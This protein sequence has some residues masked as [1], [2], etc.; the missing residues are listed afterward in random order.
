MM[1]LSF[2]MVIIAFVSSSSLLARTSC[3]DC[4]MLCNKNVVAIDSELESALKS[5]F[6]R[7]LGYTLIGKKPVTS[8]WDLHYLTK[9]VK[10]IKKL[11]EFLI[12]SF[13]VSSKFILKISKESDSSFGIEL[14]HKPALKRVIRDNQE[15][16]SFI[17]EKFGCISVFFSY[18]KNK[19]IFRALDHDDFLLGLVLGYGRDNAEYYCR[20]DAIGSYLRKD[21]IYV[22]APLLAKP[23]T[24]IYGGPIAV[25]SLEL[26]SDSPPTSIPKEEF[27]SLEA[28]WKWIQKVEWNLEKQCVL[29]PPYY[30]HL[31]FYICRHGGDSEKVREGYLKASGHLANL[32]YKHSF[33]E[34][35]L[36]QAA[37][38]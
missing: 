16:Q 37:E 38:K 10:V 30:V 19:S 1:F 25:Y 24:N 20:K 2:L 15:L 6:I 22:T 28:E 18:L 35:V 36:E 23:E 33:A 8:E 14:I 34:A 9:N 5:L 26:S 11:R 21:L 31:P 7:E 13:R 29:K 12:S 3:E 32:Y 27:G 4:E 17:Q